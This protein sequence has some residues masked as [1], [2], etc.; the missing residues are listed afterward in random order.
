MIELKKE[1][2]LKGT[3]YKQLYKDSQVVIYRI[4]RPSEDNSKEIVWYEVFKPC[5]KA[6]DIYHDD[7]YEKYP[8]DEAFG[9]WA[10]CCSNIDVVRKVLSHP[11]RGHFNFSIEETN[12]ILSICLPEQA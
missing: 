8:Y 3:N 5:R 11:T 6:P 2:K 7:Y 4:S 10:W 12:K 1:F 9:D